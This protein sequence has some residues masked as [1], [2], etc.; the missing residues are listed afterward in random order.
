MAELDDIDY[1][2]GFDVSESLFAGPAEVKST[3]A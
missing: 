2:F 3:L 1:N